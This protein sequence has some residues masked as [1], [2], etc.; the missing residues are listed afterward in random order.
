[1]RHRTILTVLAVLVMTAGPVF[2][3]EAKV[4]FLW[5]DDQGKA[6]YTENFNAI[7]QPFRKTAVKGTFTPDKKAEPAKPKCENATPVASNTNYYVKGGALH[8]EGEISN[9]FAGTVSYVRVKV[10]FF[11]AADQFVKAESTYVDP[12]ELAPCQKGSFS[13]VS[14]FIESIANFKIEFTSG[15]KE[16]KVEGV[17]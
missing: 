9:G 10:N 2:A 15:A 1:M 11:D 14:P 4:L 6:H 8:V 16:L 5:I 3:E 12:L 13:I 17:P 7:P